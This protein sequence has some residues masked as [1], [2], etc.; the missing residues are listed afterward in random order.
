[1]KITY[2]SQADA[3]YIYVQGTPS[4]RVGRTAEI[5]AGIAADFG[6]DGTVLG[7]EILDASHALN[8]PRGR[9][10]VTLEDITDR[11][12]RQRYRA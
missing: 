5:A 3:L 11:G 1:M 6:A 4:D 2:D 8:F 9:P 10:E 12:E 7:I